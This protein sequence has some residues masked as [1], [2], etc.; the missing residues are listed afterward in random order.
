MK[1]PACGALNA[2]DAAWCGQCLTRFDSRS[3]LPQPLEQ[4]PVEQ[5]PLRSVPHTGVHRSGDSLAWICPACAT[6]NSIDEIACTACGT[7]LA[8]L[9]GAEEKTELKRTGS[10]AVGLSVVMPGAGHL[11]AG[12]TAEGIGRVFLYLWCVAVGVFLITRSSPK[13]GAVLHSIGA[14]FLIAA[15]IVWV[16]VL[17]ESQRIAIGRAVTLIPGKALL[18]GMVALT[19][20]LFI[21]LAA[22]V[23][24]K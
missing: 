14:V 3:T 6:Q 15:A 17:L 19:C 12:R 16:M 24:T 4:A 21:G 22:G 5:A 1:C 11:W 7:P 18:W 8:K 2:A 23:R 13:T 9:F 10:T 20:V